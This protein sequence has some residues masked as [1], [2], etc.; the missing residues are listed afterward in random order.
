MEW[1]NLSIMSE[2]EGSERLRNTSQPP[3]TPVPKVHTWQPER[4]TSGQY[5]T[6]STAHRE[7]GVGRYTYKQYTGRHIGVVYSSHLPREAYKGGLP[8]IL[9]P[10]EAY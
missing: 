10:R 8:S 1:P 4:C 9:L 7:D 3:S 2:R 5:G 6:Y